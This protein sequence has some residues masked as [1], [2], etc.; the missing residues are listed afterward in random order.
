MLG[1]LARCLR[2]VMTTGAA[3]GDAIMGKIGRAPVIRCMAAIALATGGDMIGGFAG[4]RH[5]IVT[6]G[7]TTG[8]S[9]MIDPTY[10][11]PA[12]DGVTQLAFCG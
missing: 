7:A 4:C 12:S 5:A 3:A 2:A 10:R 11:R 8:D 1:I 9:I 6:A